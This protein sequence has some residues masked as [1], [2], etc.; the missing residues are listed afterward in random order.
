MT[1]EEI[2]KLRDALA[3]TLELHLTGRKYDD[4]SLKVLTETVQS[5]ML[6]ADE[7]V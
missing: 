2:I 6:I 5:F 4:E 1:D 3:K 7:I